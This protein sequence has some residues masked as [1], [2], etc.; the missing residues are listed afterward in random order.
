MFSRID[1]AGNYF[2]IPLRDILMTCV[3]TVALAKEKSTVFLFKA[4]KKTDFSFIIRVYILGR[5]QGF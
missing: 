5:L 2:V 1:A 3:Y 4:V